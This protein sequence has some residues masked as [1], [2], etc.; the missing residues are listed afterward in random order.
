MLV[1]DGGGA[2]DI[3]V[4][5]L[6]FVSGRSP[7]SKPKKNVNIVGSWALAPLVDFYFLPITST[8]KYTII[9]YRLL[10]GS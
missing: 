4:N 1:L 8:V 2:I 7:S 3:V 10:Q 9:I 5:K 6:G